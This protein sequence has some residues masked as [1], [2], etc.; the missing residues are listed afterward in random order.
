MKTFLQFVAVIILAVSANARNKVF[1]ATHDSI[2]AENRRADMQNLKRYES[3]NDVAAGVA[4]HTLVLLRTQTSPKL[5][6][7]RRYALPETVA[8]AEKL[9][10]DFYEATG[11]HLTVDSAIRPSDVQKRLQRRNRNAAPADG[12]RASTHERGTTFDLSRRM[13]M[14]SYRWLLARLAYYKAL[15]QIL[16]IEERSCIHVFVGMDNHESLEVVPATDVESVVLFGGE[17]IPVQS[18]QSTASALWDCF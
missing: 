12:A 5:P 8:F 13:R 11:A 3:M 18:G 6:L 7:E 2:S 14:S 15:G 9:D 16:V 17:D 10:S 4:S 1:P